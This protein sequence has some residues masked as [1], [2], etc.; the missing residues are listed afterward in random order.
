MHELGIVFHIIKQ[1]EEVCA[2]KGLKA[3]A[4]VT[5][6]VGEV[7]TIVDSYLGDC[8]KWAVEKS[9][10]MKG[11]ALRIEKLPAVTMCDSCGRTYG[12]VEHGR[13]CPFCASGDTHLV[14]GSEVMIK[15]IEAR[16]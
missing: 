2:G 11:C 1:V 12:T 10:V 16:E 4:S 7:S 15:E 8:W 6:E 5:L 13:T 14:S 9:E 3:V